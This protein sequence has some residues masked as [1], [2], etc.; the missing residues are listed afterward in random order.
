MARISYLVGTV[1]AL[2]GTA[3]AQFGSNVPI[4][5]RSLDEIYAAAL[6]ETGTLNVASG[7]D[8]GWQGDGT[9]AAFEGRFP[10]LKLNLTVDLSKYHDSRIDRAY[11]AGN[12]YIDIAILQT[13][14]DFPRW[15]DQ[16]RLLNYKPANFEDIYLGEKDLNGA[17]LPN[18]FNSFGNFVYD[19]TKVAAADVPKN[20]MDILDPKW[21]GKLV[22][23]YPNDDDAVTYLFSIIVEKYGFGWLDALA[24]QDVQWVRGSETPSIKIFENHSN[25]TDSDRVLTFTSIG[26]FKGPADFITSTPVEVPETKMSWCQ[27][28]AIFKSTKVPETAKLFMSFMSSP[29]MQGASGGLSTLMSLDSGNVYSSNITQISWFR[30]FMHD[31]ATVDWW[32]LQFETTLGSAQGP[33]PLELYPKG[34]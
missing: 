21:K 3:C 5:T 15:R 19:S 13:L 2:C 18:S 20:Y 17:F 31:R 28:M 32:K 30:N 33:G 27:T 11:L 14:H 29:E 9:V 23:T 10:G 25:S 12:E 22:L 26:Y 4:D 8:A 34:S 7:G 1:T 24:Q 6:K 16:Q